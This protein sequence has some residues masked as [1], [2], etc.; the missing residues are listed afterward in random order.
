MSTEAG[1]SF[2]SK[3]PFKNL[4]SHGTF[5]WSNKEISRSCPQKATI[6]LDEIDKSNYF[7]SLEIKGIQL[8]KKCLF[9]KTW[10]LHKNNGNL[11]HSRLSSC[12]PCWPQLSQNRFLCQGPL[13]IREFIQFG[14]VDYIRAQ[15]H[16]LWKWWSGPA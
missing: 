11:W 13:L 1:S 5:L 10:I 2:Y 9:L 6:K 15:Q 14:M 8:S 12:S 3:K 4:D 16:C 7:S